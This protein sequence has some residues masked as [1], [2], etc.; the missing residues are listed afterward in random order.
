MDKLY[1][2]FN[3]GRDK[4]D[5]VGGKQINHGTNKFEKISNCC[6]ASGK[7]GYAITSTTFE[8]AELCS[9]CGEFC[10]YIEPDDLNITKERLIGALQGCL[11]IIEMASHGVGFQDYKLC[12]GYIDA[13]QLLTSIEENNEIE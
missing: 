8:E 4:S 13:K 9:K 3:N 7:G 5:G 11:S 10:E 2:G 1:N 12:A 6:G